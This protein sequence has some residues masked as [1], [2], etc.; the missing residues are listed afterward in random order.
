MNLGQV[1][2]GARARGASKIIGVD[3]N[4]EKLTIGNLLF[5]TFVFVLTLR[6]SGERGSSNLLFTP[7]LLQELRTRYYI[8]TALLKL[9]SSLMWLHNLHSNLTWNA[10]SLYSAKAMGITDFINPR[11]E[12]KSVVEVG[13]FS[14]CISQKNTSSA[15][16]W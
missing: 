6:F 7:F 16:A 13:V 1:A 14:P 3:V 8:V 11:D 10:F 12:E 15:H 2:L 9:P 5:T 4:P